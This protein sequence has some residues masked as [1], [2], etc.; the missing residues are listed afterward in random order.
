MIDPP[1]LDLAYYAGDHLAEA[2][3]IAEKVVA[4][5]PEEHPRRHGP[6]ACESTNS[7]SVRRSVLTQRMGPYWSS[8]H[9][10]SQ[11]RWP[12]IQNRSLSRTAS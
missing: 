4:S 5:W 9:L 12:E 3:T 8:T 11:T 1:F 6:G 10:K 2:Q 7:L